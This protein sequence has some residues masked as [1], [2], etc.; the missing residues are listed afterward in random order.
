MKEIFNYTEKDLWKLLREKVQGHL[1]RI[2]NI[3]TR[4]V[5]DLHACHQGKTVW[6]ELKIGSSNTVYFQNS[7]IGFIGEAEKHGEKVKVLMRKDNLLYLIDGNI[8]LNLVAKKVGDDKISFKINELSRAYIWGEPW[9]WSEIT[10][11]IYE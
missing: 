2:E 5:P 6:I 3:T 4:G 11:R 10:Q 1:V 7:Q 9:K 8:L